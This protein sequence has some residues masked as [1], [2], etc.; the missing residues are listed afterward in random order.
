VNKQKHKKEN[1]NKFNLSRIK[2]SFSAECKRKSSELQ[3]QTLFS[4]FFDSFASSETKKG[5]E[6]LIKTYLQKEQKGRRKG[7]KLLLG[8]L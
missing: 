4:Y 8:S 7:G 2:I 1:E 5:G 6:K 3:E